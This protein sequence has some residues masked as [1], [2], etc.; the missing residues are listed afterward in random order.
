MLLPMNFYLLLIFSRQ[1][2]AIHS[3]GIRV[4]FIAMYYG[5]SCAQK[6][7]H[8]YFRIF[9]RTMSLVLENLEN[10]LLNCYD[11]VGLL[12]MI[13]VILKYSVLF[14]FIILN[15][16]LFYLMRQMSH[17]LRLI[18]QRRRIPVLD[19]MFDRISMLLWPRFK[20]VLAANITSIKSANPKKLGTLDLTP[21]IIVRYVA[22]H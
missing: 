2:L 18:M 6:F 4:H 19:A 15:S 11:A 5:I 20:Q 12:I 10:Y 1:I 21:H 17:L 14:N 22:L 8:V 3:T 9:G 16:E 13:K 7:A